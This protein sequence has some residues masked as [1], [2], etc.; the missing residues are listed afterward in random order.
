[1]SWK[2]TMCAL[3]FMAVDKHDNVFRPCCQQTDTNWAQNHSISEYFNSDILDKL[4]VDLSSGIRNAGC[5]KCWQLEDL[6]MT[7]LRQSVN[8]SRLTV[9]VVSHPTL[10]QVKLITG[11][12]CN[13]S[14][15]MCFSTVSST[16]GQ[17]W[18][19]DASWTMPKTKQQDIHYDLDMDSYIRSHADKIQYIDVLGGEPMFCKQFLDLLDHLIQTGSSKNITLFVITN[20]TI[21]TKSLRQRFL[22]FKKV[23][24]TVSVDGIGLV[25]EYQRWPSKWST[26]SSNLQEF[27]SDFDVTLSPTITAL[28]IIHLGRLYDFSLQHNYQ[29]NNTQL[30]DHWPQL[31]PKNLPDQLKQKI[32]EDFRHVAQGE[33]DPMSLLQFIQ[34]WDLQRKISIQN[35]MPEWQMI[36]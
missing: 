25:N 9:A 32:P 21:Y 11:K 18:A 3:P 36:I 30:V 23:V 35:Y 15:M 7:S 5:Q 13:I 34:R 22:K 14:C 29:I 6:G 20:G 1:M 24:F 33:A 4:R 8:Q 2:K 17:T 27:A 10:T 28:N 19:N 26:V 31:L 16:Y 12:V